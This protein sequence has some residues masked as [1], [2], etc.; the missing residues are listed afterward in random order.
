MY[1]EHLVEI[2]TIE[3][4]KMEC[5]ARLDRNNVMDWVKTIAGFANAEEGSFFVGVEN[6]TNKLIGFSRKDADNERNFF[7]NK[8]NEHVFPRPAMKISFIRYERNERELYLMRVAIPSLI[9]WNQK[10]RIQGRIIL[11]F[12]RFIKNTTMV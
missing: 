11:S 4:I 7:I 2:S 8:I 12:W 1:L 3:D 5:K 9:H 10:N 6:K